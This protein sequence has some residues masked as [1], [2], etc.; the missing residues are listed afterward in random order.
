MRNSLIG[1]LIAGSVVLCPLTQSAVKADIVEL[2][3]GEQ[4]K[5][6]V[7][8]FDGRVVT[9]VQKSNKFKIGKNQIKQIIFEKKPSNKYVRVSRDAA[10]A[11][12]KKKKAEQKKVASKP[13]KKM[14]KAQK[15]QKPQKVTNKKPEKKVVQKT[16]TKATKP[17]LRPRV[18]VKTEPK[19]ATTQKQ[20]K[21]DVVITKRPT[22]AEHKRIAT[23][24]ADKETKAKQAEN[25]MPSTVVKIDKRKTSPLIDVITYVNGSKSNDIYAGIYSNSP[26]AENLTIYIKPKHSKSL[27]F[28]LHAQKNG[29]FAP[30][31][32]AASAIF[33]DKSGKVISSTK[34]IVV[35]DK[36]LVE[37]FQ[38]LENVAGVT[39][40]KKVDI[41][42]P[43]ATYAIKITGIR[44][45]SR[46]N[47]VG[48]VS[49]I[50]LD[51]TLIE[52]INK[53]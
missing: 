21:P 51:G 9:L 44:P 12:Q 28:N 32:T 34:P 37:W 36:N 48:Y 31:Y 19:K 25:K 53:D 26:E 29:N 45:G 39:S 5:G 52:N 18:A 7:K 20:K 10:K 42:I 24:K 1:L 13:E 38:N 33:I 40:G 16:D 2:M 22:V 23:I 11:A 15:K 43:E 35:D 8:S 3:T 50:Q 41:N 17:S 14:T 6:T 30:L 4:L 49:N 27:S 46:N 47:L